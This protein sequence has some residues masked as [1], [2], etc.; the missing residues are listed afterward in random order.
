MRFRNYLKHGLSFKESF[1]G[2]CFPVSHSLLSIKKQI[3]VFLSLRLC[4]T[5]EIQVI[6]LDAYN[7]SGIPG[8]VY[9]IPSG[10]HI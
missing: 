2:S 8:T 1:V 6:G 10:F 3:K 7:Q 5:A 9:L 4:I